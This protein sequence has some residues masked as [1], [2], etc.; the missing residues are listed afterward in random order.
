VKILVIGLDC[1]APELLLGDDQLTNF[2]RLMEYG[3]YARLE[4]VI[5]PITVPAWMCMATSQ[6]PGSLGVYG[7]RNRKDHSY[8]GLGIVNSRS[9]QELAIWDQVAREGKRAEAGESLRLFEEKFPGSPLRVYL[10][11]E[12][13]YAAALD[14]ALEMSDYVRLRQQQGEARR[15]GRH[16][17]IG[18]V[19]TI[20]PNLLDSPMSSVPRTRACRFSSA[21]SSARPSKTGFSEARNASNAG[22][23]GITS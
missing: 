18:V 11:H 6:D 2:R 5:P 12:V 3:C 15:A 17:G 20:E 7:F 21:R 13:A 8:S 19:S 9:I 16:V 10:R 14:K 22:P 23:I 1:A 4:S